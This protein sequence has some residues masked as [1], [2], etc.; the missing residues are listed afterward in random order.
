MD[1]SAYF[2]G[3]KYRFTL[4]KTRLLIAG[5]I[6]SLVGWFILWVTL[7]GQ[8]F[9]NE[10]LAL[11]NVVQTSAFTWSLRLAVLAFVMLMLVNNKLLTRMWGKKLFRYAMYL[12]FAVGLIGWLIWLIGVIM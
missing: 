11:E 10:L 12:I 8:F 7:F 4:F 6:M 2:N 5:F 3:W 1:N 9:T